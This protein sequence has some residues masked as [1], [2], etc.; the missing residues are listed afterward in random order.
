MTTKAVG[1]YDELAPIMIWII[2]KEIKLEFLMM[3]S[4]WVFII[5]KC[6][7]DIHKPRNVPLIITVPTLKVKN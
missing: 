5:D 3:Q 2:E 4:S 1:Q 6:G 7:N